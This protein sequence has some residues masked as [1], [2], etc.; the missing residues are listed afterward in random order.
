MLSNSVGLVPAVLCALSRRPDR[1]FVVLVI[2]DLLAVS[3][4]SS[5]YWLWPVSAGGNVTVSPRQAAVPEIRPHILTICTCVL[6]ISCSWWQ[7]FVSGDSFLPPVRALAQFSAGLA[8]ARSKTYVLVS[9]CKCL[10]YLFC[11]FFFLTPRLSVNDLMQRDPFGEK[12]ITITAEDMN[13]TQIAAFLQRM[14][15]YEQPGE[16]GGDRGQ[17]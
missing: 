3:A 8:E 16:C 12:L 9:P 7:N 11:L 2:L 17:H 4:Q 13:Q 1:W 14:H 6:F 10:I 15:E 5:V